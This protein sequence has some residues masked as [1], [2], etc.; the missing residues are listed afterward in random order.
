M[1][2][3]PAKRGEQ[4]AAEGSPRLVAS[5][6]AYELPL[7]PPRVTGEAEVMR[8]AAGHDRWSCPKCN[9]G[10]PHGPVIAVH[11]N[12]AGGWAETDA[13]VCVARRIG[14]K[15][16][17]GFVQGEICGAPAEHRVH[18]IDLCETHFHILER[19]RVAETR[20]EEIRR[21]SAELREA[22]RELVE[23][24]AG[25]EREADAAAAAWER[26]TARHSV[27]YYLRRESD[28]M[29]KIG[30]SKRFRS[31]LEQHRAD[32]GGLQPLLLRAGE[33]QEE[34]RTHRKFRAY[35][36]GRTE[37]FLPARPLMEHIYRARQSSLHADIQPTDV[38]PIAELRRLV[39]A[40][41]R[42]KDIIGEDGV[43]RWPPGSAAA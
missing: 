2:P 26:A 9:R 32:H 40:A 16:R 29:I 19:W 5:T 24:K 41:P 21:E 35:Q 10:R 37:W 33:Y 6:P 7:M 31:R 43:V 13:P 25:Y 3:V 23:A 17:P 14:L 36:L 30:T 12:E 11:D 39:Y 4:S 18:G 27:V 15:G 20:A 34:R 8:H 28:G 42:K 22:T 38:L 1:A